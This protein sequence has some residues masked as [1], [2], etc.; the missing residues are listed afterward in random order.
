MFFLSIHTQRIKAIGYRV[1][2]CPACVQQQPF[3]VYE[4]SQS[5]ALYGITVKNT[6]LQRFERCEVCG[7]IN[8]LD[9]K[10][11]VAMAADWQPGDSIT[12]LASAT[13]VPLVD[14]DVNPINDATIVALI[15]RVMSLEHKF[16]GNITVMGWVAGVVVGG[17]IGWIAWHAGLA[18]GKD[19]F[20]NVI[21]LGFP[22]AITGIV[23]RTVR[24]IR[25]SNR[26]MYHDELAF[27]AQKWG[28][29]VNR[30]REALDRRMVNSEKADRILD[31]LASDTHIE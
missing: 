22:S 6:I 29:T 16:D 20:Q 7:T 19:D 3:G 28:L 5:D 15:Q 30:I 25:E 18:I 17:V 2:D 23:V 14:P 26:N 27:S 8:P 4:L 12:T 13:G 10:A 9:K 1:S 11:E 21:F 31:R 24:E